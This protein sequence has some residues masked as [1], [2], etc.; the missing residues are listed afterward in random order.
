[1]ETRIPWYIYLSEILMANIFLLFINNFVLGIA[2]RPALYSLINKIPK[3]NTILIG[4]L[5]ELA[6]VALIIIVSRKAIKYL[7]IYTKGIRTNCIL[8]EVNKRSK[9]AEMDHHYLLIF[10]YTTKDN[11]VQKVDT[12][13]NVDYTDAPLKWRNYV[14]FLYKERCAP[15]NKDMIAS[16]DEMTEYC[17]E[18]QKNEIKEDIQSFQEIVDGKETPQPP[19][20][21]VTYVKQGNKY[22]AELDVDLEKKYKVIENEL[23]YTKGYHFFGFGA[24]FSIIMLLLNISII[25]YTIMLPVL[26]SFG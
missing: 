10:E 20:A 4:L 24:I 26:F 1:M 15:G 2:F 11:T 9:N 21:K 6:I 23:R 7:D 8:T 5:L 13:I 17:N 16:F 18:E 14:K 25:I 3:Y 22:L 12:I 19:V